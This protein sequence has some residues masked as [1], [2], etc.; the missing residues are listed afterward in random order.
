MGFQAWS[1]QFVLYTLII[2]A[3]SPL[4]LRAPRFSGYHQQDSQ[5]LLRYLLDA[6]RSEEITV[7]DCIHLEVHSTTSQLPSLLYVV[8]AEPHLEA[9]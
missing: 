3:V 5:E 2:I 7:S 4:T 1:V 8:T 9:L 6:L